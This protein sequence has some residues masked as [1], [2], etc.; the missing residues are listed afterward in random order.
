MSLVRA[1]WQHWFGKGFLLIGVLLWVH[2][3]PARGEDL[4]AHAGTAEGISGYAV[5]RISE[6]L[7]VRIQDERGSDIAAAI[8]TSSARGTVE[9]VY[10]AGATEITVSWSSH[11]G[12]LQVFHGG[13]TERAVFS[14]Q[15]S[16]WV[17]SRGWTTVEAILSQDLRRVGALW[18][19]LSRKPAPLA[20]Q[21][22]KHE[23]TNWW[24]PGDTECSGV[25]H[26]GFAMSTTR[27][28]CCW[29]AHVSANHACNNRYCWGCCFH[30]DCDAACAIGDYFCFCGQSGRACT[31]ND[32]T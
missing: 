31:Y 18:A 29:G 1:S 26:R 21:E 6:R 14:L 23:R 17:Y 5:A 25:W 15:E 30:L 11:Q 27:S 8:V 4:A 12:E 22:C 16:S 7:D 28:D 2:P 3:L 19:D 9:I 32:I 20:A 24:E 10:R 13:Q